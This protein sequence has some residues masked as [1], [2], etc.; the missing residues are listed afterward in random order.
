MK[1]L[2]G[3]EIEDIPADWEQ[4]CG[5]QLWRGAAAIKVDFGEGPVDLPLSQ[6]RVTEIERRVDGPYVEITMP[7]WLAKDRGLME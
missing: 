5:R 1:D 7:A 6:I 3:E 4:F 2:F